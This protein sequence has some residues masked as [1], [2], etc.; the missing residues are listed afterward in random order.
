M[1]C[2][3]G[4]WRDAPGD[5]P[6]GPMLRQEFRMLQSLLPTLF[7]VQP[8][9]SMQIDANA[10][11][12]YVYAGRQA[13]LVGPN[14]ERTWAEYGDPLGL[15]APPTR[16]FRLRTAPP[17]APHPA[18]RREHQYCHVFNHLAEGPEG[19]RLWLAL[20]AHANNLALDEG[21][22]LLT[23][24]FDPD[25]RFHALFRRGAMNHIE[26]RL[27]MKALRP[28]VPAEL[29]RFYPDVRDMS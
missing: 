15:Q 28:G 21:A 16:L 11:R 14:D 1:A 29:A 19:I 12:L 13:R 7:A 6:H 8:P 2:P 26:Y 5:R 23:S 20:V 10:G 25:D 9:F 18:R 4:T 22:T 24:A 17:A 3:E 27:G